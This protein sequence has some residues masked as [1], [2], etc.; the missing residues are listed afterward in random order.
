M[1]VKHIAELS[2]QLIKLAK[3]RST[4][5]RPPNHSASYAPDCG[6]PIGIAVLATRRT[7]RTLAASSG[8]SAGTTRSLSITAI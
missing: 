7:T 4:R 2:E 8:T 5:P 1:V 6:S 3:I